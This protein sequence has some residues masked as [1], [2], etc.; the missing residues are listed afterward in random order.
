[1]KIFIDGK[2]GTTGLQIFERFKDRNDVT[3]ITI[4]EHLRKDI[5]RK[6]ELINQADLVF[7]CLPDEFAKESVSLIENDT[8]RVIDAS[9]AHRVNDDW[10]YGFAELSPAHKEAIRNSKRV[11]N[12][13]CYASGF[14]S[15]CYPMVA[16]GIMSQEHAVSGYGISGFSGGGK[17]MIADYEENPQKHKSPR[18]Y[19]L[20]QEHKH[21]PEM[22]K[23]SGLKTKPI[24]NPI[25]DNYYSGMV[26]SVPLHVSSLAK[27]YGAEDIHKMFA[28]H[29]SEQKM[30]TVMPYQKQP[31]PFMSTD[32]LSD[33]SKMQIFIYGNDEQVLLCSRL[34]NLGKGA[35]GNAVQ[36]MNFMMGI[37]ESTG[38]L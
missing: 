12:P 24:F 32:E 2:E 19:A 8:T 9:T 25:V 6:K 11:A 17:A 34:D 23:I 26:V 20:T 28:E 3:I 33:T 14:I 1:M 37:D 29:Y 18:F 38:L 22:Q 15:L 10:T 21:L 5:A 30:L 7:L 13:G 36:C 16:S 31:E 4:E 27:K 35:S